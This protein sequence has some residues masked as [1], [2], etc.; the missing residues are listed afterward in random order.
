MRLV[1]EGSLLYVVVWVCSL[2]S[3]TDE[4]LIRLT[5]YALVFG[6]CGFGA[7]DEEGMR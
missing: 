2:G 3:R 7:G 1:G 5:M 4:V 6:V